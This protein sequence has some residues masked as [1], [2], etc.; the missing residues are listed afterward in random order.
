[1]SDKKV[2]FHHL[3]DGYE[4]D[5]DVNGTHDI[6]KVYSFKTITA[7]ECDAIIAVGS[8]HVKKV[9]AKAKVPSAEKKE[10]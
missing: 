3:I 6:G 9:E 1:M 4:T 5:L 2:R 7:A 8:A 10:I